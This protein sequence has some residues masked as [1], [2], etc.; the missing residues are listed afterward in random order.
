MDIVNHSA[1]SALSYDKTVL[2]TITDDTEKEEG[3]YI[4]SDGAKS[5]DAYST[6]T[7][8][9]TKD[10][11]YV[12]IPEGK[13]ENQK[14]I[15]GKK[16][17][18]EEKPFIYS[19]PFDNYF[20]MTVN[21]AAS[22][23]PG[24]LV[25]NDDIEHVELLEAFDISEYNVVKY[26]RLGIRADIRSWV[27]NA[28]VGTYG[29]AVALHTEK[30]STTGDEMKS[31]TYTYFFD[32]SKMYGNPYS[33]ETWYN[34]E[35]VLD[36]SKT[37]IGKVKSIDITFYQEKNFKNNQN[38]LIPHLEKNGTDKVAPNLFI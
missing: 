28:R 27:K 26:N 32:S 25:A 16:T 29:L 1:L 18:K 36:L 10:N 37:D 7:K 12:M 33:F 3:K 14:M 6:D 5:F 38:Q 13:Y 8:L 2:C 34:Q 19:S 17:S 4:V 23:K 15:V 24:E 31:G 9:K 30:P 35:I 20:P 11:V 22:A 21:F